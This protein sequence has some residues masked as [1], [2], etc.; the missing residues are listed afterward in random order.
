MS[1]ISVSVVLFLLVV[2]ACKEVSFENP[3]PEG[4]KALTSVPRALQG[5]YLTLTDEGTP[6]KD[7]VVITEHGYRFGY[8]DVAE[9][10]GKNDRYEEGVLSDTLVLKSYKGYYFLN[11]NEKPEWLLRVLR[12][13]KNGD[14]IYMSLQ[15][16]NTDFNDFLKKLSAEIRVDS[17]QKENET[18]Y[19]IDPTPAMLM[20]LIHKGYF[21]ESRLIRIKEQAVSR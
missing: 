2:F 11:L 1:R 5:K 16:K 3:Q 14:L 6:S 15:E 9:R 10:S 18:L 17:I 12:Q 8:F 7:T 20:K 21:A 13:E 19:Q 4:R